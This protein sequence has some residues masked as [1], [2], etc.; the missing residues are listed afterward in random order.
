MNITSIN[1]PYIQ[2]QTNND[3]CNIL[4]LKFQPNSL[5]SHS[6]QVQFQ[7]VLL[8]DT[9]YSPLPPDLLPSQGRDENRPFPKTVVAV[10]VQVGNYI[11]YEKQNIRWKYSMIVSIRVSQNTS[12]QG[13]SIQKIEKKMGKIILK[14]D[15]M[16]FS[17][18]NNQ[19]MSNSSAALFYSVME[20]VYNEHLQ[21]LPCWLIQLEV[22]VCVIQGVSI[23]Q[24]PLPQPNWVMVHMKTIYFQNPISIPDYHASFQTYSAIY[25][26]P[27]L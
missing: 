22:F 16:F 1:I 6:L 2:V 12:C 20:Y 11:F 7:F 21:K 13:K 27:V 5:H 24:P 26:L 17:P 18:Y 23:P 4:F 8:T 14:I 9:L 19:I 25:L 3:K 15:P 10:E